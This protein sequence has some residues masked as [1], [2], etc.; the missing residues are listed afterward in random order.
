V[1]VEV[2]PASLSCLP[3]SRTGASGLL[4]IVGASVD[5]EAYAP[6]LAPSWWTAIQ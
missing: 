4:L 2:S 6:L 1:S 5:A 3:T